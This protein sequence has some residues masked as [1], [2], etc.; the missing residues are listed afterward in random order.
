M[1]GSSNDGSAYLYASSDSATIDLSNSSSNQL[2]GYNIY[3]HDGDDVLT[4]SSG[5]DNIV[6]GG[7]NDSLTGG[8]GNDIFGV[9]AGSDIIT[10][11]K[12]G[13]SLVVNAHASAQA[14]IS[15]N[16]IATNKTRIESDN[17]V[18]LSITNPNIEIIDVS[19]AKGKQGFAIFP[20]S[21]SLNIKG[22]DM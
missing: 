10:D 18:L 9:N 14:I 1:E 3:G 4:G 16:F 19:E 21:D 20:A 12:T 2:S 8:G 15:E 11:L 17:S 13:D 7:G 22:S 6:G 5:N